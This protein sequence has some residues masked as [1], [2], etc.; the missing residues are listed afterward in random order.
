MLAVAVV[1]AGCSVPSAPRPE[2]KPP[3]TPLAV[4]AATHGYP[5]PPARQSAPAAVSPVAAIAAFATAYI[6]WG[7]ETVTATMLTLAA[8]SIGQARAAMQLAAA[9]TAG[10]YELRRGGIANRGV[11]QAVARLR[12]RRD[13][14]VVVTEEQTTATATT[15]YQGLRP[16]WHV[17]V[18]TLT[19]PTAG[20]WV[21]S[22]WQPES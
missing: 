3:P 14:W 4:A 16:A 13:Q 10:D 15:A 22:S 6:N 1:L 5:S 21:I 9:Q 20:R 8:R 2:P 17:T 18:V 11:V 19:E 12:G 7:P